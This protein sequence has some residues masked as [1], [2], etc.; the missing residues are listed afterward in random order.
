MT[1]EVQWLFCNIKHLH[2]GSIKNEDAP[3][4]LLSEGDYWWGCGDLNLSHSGDITRPAK[5]LL[6]FNSGIKF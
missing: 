2:N 1:V 6:F 3:R 5:L 4:K